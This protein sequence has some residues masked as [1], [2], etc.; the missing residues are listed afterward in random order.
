MQNQKAVKLYDRGREL[1]QKTKLS[2]AERAYK[3]AIKI[4]PKFVE[5]HN[6]LGNVLVD[7]G[8]L[9]EAAGAYRKALKLRPDH[10]MLLNNLGNALQLQGENEK[11]IEYFRKALALDRNYA[12]AYNNLGNALKAIDILDGA[13]DSYLMAIKLD[14]VNKEARIGLGSV[15]RKM[16]KFD[17]AITQFQKVIEIDP[18]HKA[19]YYGLGFA[20]YK[21]GNTDEAITHYRKVIEIDP[22]HKNA[23]FGLANAMSDIGYIEKAVEY[24]RKVIEIQPDDADAYRMLSAIKK[25]TENDN[26]LRIMESLFTAKGISDE[27]KMSLAFG[28]SKAY[29]DLQEYE[30]AMEM[31]LE[32]NRLKHKSVNFSIS[33]TKEHFNQIKNTFSE[34]FFN[35]REAAGNQDPTPIF[36]LGMPRSGTSL[37]EQILA[38]HPDVFGAS[39]LTALSKLA[40]QFDKETSGK[41]GAKGIANMNSDDFQVLG[42]E[43]ISEIR[44]YSPNVR[45]ITDKMPHNFLHI[46]FIKTILPCAKIVHCTRDPMDNCLSIFKN[47]FGE[48]H[49]YS[50]DMTDLGRYYKLYQD[51]MEFWRVTLPGFIYELRYEALVADQENETR[52]LLEYCN[53]PWDDACL[54]FHKTRRRV[55]TISNA[56]VRRPI[57]KGSVGLWKQYEEQL[58]PLQNSIYGIQ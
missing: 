28:L 15:Y 38:S 56:Q 51:L 44:K 13:V 19:A 3:K 11:A 55:H 30:K 23:Y 36:I 42:G 18:N 52:K 49:S 9:K 40:K 7:R 4:N 20:F 58:A 14:S 31:T 50:Y 33:D 45:Y 57:Y 54:D 1:H 26:D 39:E 34:S 29:E 17:E 5:A 41:I 25:F 21:D 32:A 6:N 2:A 46:G 24:H 8:R 53:L 16:E 10:P 22:N 37:T 35:T 12:D 47:Y 48:G 43:Y 27:Q